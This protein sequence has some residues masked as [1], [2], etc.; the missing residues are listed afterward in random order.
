MNRHTD[1]GSISSAFLPLGEGRALFAYRRLVYA[2]PLTSLARVDIDGAATE[3]SKKYRNRNFI[4]GYTSTMNY[5]YQFDREYGFKY[6]AEA[7]L[8]RSRC[9]IADE[10]NSGK[11]GVE[12]R[13]A[14]S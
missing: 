12:Q 14:G 4:P 6:A 9:I 7:S 3:E 2:L 8:S 1:S 10:S 11:G 13:R 5:L